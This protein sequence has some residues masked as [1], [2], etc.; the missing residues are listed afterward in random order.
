MHRDG[1][2]RTVQ[3]TGCSQSPGTGGGACAAG[4]STE[5]S[6]TMCV[7]SSSSRHVCCSAAKR[8][9]HACPRPIAPPTQARCAAR[10][11]ALLM[12][13]ACRQ[14]GQRS[15][16]QV[17]A[18]LRK[19]AGGHAHIAHEVA[20]GQEG[21]E[22]QARV[23]VGLLCA[24]AAHKVQVRAQVQQRL[25][26]EHNTCHIIEPKTDTDLHACTLGSNWRCCRRAG[27]AKGPCS[28]RER[29]AGPTRLIP[30]RT[31]KAALG[32]D[33]TTADTMIAPPWPSEPSAS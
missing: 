20:G 25:A 7:P 4:W 24:L 15:G 8:G 13:V 16:P 32:V 17:S 33:R 9:A 19:R 18:M 11:G 29:C 12:L 21:A 10:A 22:E 14:A 3:G 27:N 31:W 1:E 6:S 23:R 5:C 28:W 26:N 30:G 2:G